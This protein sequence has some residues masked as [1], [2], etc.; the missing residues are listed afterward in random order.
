MKFLASL[1][2]FPVC[3]TH[4]LLRIDTRVMLIVLTELS[5]SLKE[6]Q[7]FTCKCAQLKCNQKQQ[8]SCTPHQVS[9]DIFTITVASLRPLIPQ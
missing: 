5:H 2:L 7:G 4:F 1:G 6:N 8:V 3:T 9:P